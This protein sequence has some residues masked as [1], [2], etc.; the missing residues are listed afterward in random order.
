MTILKSVRLNGTVNFPVDYVTPGLRVYYDASNPNSYPGSGNS[1]FNI[2]SSA[3][4]A[5]MNGTTYTADKGGGLVFSGSATGVSSGFGWTNN[6]FTISVWVYPTT[7][8]S[9]VRRF[10][11]LQDST[12]NFNWGV[13]RLDG[14]SG[15]QQFH[16]FISHS[17]GTFVSLRNNNQVIA[18]T[19]QNFVTTWSGTQVV[20]YKNNAFL[21]SN[22]VG[23]VTIDYS[24]TG[25]TVRISSAGEPFAG[26]MYVIMLYDRALTA[27][28][29]TQNYDAFRER[30]GL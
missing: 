29:R 16:S 4:T 30:F 1:W 10:V 19:Y 17:G 13:S 8:D 11:T 7:V 24:A 22:T 18:N 5:T 27:Q 9:T 28:E 23:A 12:A 14:I 2:V 6:S 20:H 21:S 15:T 3:A 25:N 26:N